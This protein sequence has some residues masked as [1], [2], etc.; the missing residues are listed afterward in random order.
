MIGKSKKLVFKTTEEIISK[1]I[2]YRE[3]TLSNETKH[4]T[5]EDR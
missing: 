3:Q 5:E 2:G 1:Q 4:M